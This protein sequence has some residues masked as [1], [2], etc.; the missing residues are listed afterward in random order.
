ME[1]NL[2]ILTVV[3]NDCGLLDLM[4]KS[5]CK[6][7]YPEP[8]I[9]ICDNGRNKGALNQYN[10]KNDILIVQNTPL[11]AGGSNRHGEGLNKIFPLVKTEKTAIIESDCILL[12]K[13]WN[14]LVNYYS[15]VAAQKAQDTY[16]I[17]FLIFNTILLKGIDFCP[18]EPYSRANRTYKPHEDVGWKIKNY[19]K[20]DQIKHMNFVDC[21]VGGGRYFNKEFQSDEFW[22]DGIPLLA[23]FGRGSNLVGKTWKRGFQSINKQLE[24]WKI[25]AK[26]IIK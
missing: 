14:K 4:I 5:V 15:V 2:T 20:K 7:T 22:L 6:F 17:C 11:L 19:I 9:I 21:K 8:N 26:D 13:N 3:E 23:H 25:I 16:H 1:N 18:G 10:K 12:Y 24:N